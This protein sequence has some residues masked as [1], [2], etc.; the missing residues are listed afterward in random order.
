MRPRCDVFDARTIRAAIEHGETTERAAYL[1]YSATAAR[2]YARSTF[3]ILLRRTR[4]P[5]S[6]AKPATTCSEA[7]DQWCEHGPVKPRILSLS[8][9]GGLRVQAGS[10]IAFD[11]ARRLVYTRAAKPPSA[12]VLSSAGGFVTIEAVR[13]CARANVAIVALNR[14]HGFL[15][16]MTGAPK[17]SAALIKAQAKADPLPIARAIVAAKIEAMARAGALAAQ[18]GY[19]GA[20]ARAATLDQVR[21]VEAQASRVAWPDPPRL[22]WERGPIPADLAAPWLMRTRLD[23]KG[24]RGAR[25]PVNAMLNAA[26]AVTAG[27]LAA[28][29]AASGFAPAIGFLHAD[30]RGR[31]SLAWDAIEPLRPAIEARVFR[32]I[33]QERFD[34]RDFVR[35]RDGS[36]RLAP[37]L[38]SIALNAC[39]PPSATLA[40][41]V[42]WLGRLVL[43]AEEGVTEKAEQRLRH[44]GGLGLAVGGGALEFGDLSRIGVNLRRERL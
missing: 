13:F 26:F 10:L 11:S 18:D 30:K 9:G 36:L 20:L 8:P 19:L 1:N 28:Y 44:V 41:C 40:G 17:A 3:S 7:L 12:I 4:E 21:V 37:G 33:E 32:L 6:K 39:A 38:L 16:V 22:K 31:W 5:E 15:T 34:V 25:H 27:R 42:R 23:A 29:L 14:A 2:P 35:A 43:S 24:K